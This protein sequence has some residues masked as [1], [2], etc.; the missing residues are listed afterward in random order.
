M[1]WT[2]CMHVLI[3]FEEKN[4]ICQSRNKLKTAEKCPAEQK[5]RQWAGNKGHHIMEIPS[6]ELGY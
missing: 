1:E 2:E 3:Y 4:H 6:L 5:I